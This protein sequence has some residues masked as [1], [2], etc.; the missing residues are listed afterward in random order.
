MKRFDDAMSYSQ[1]ALELFKQ[2]QNR[3]GE[4]ICYNQIGR[5]FK[6]KGEYEKALI[7]CFDAFYLMA[8]LR[9][10]LIREAQSES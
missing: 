3:Q 4:A 1:R 10:Q 6:F 9:I 2:V 5:I 8:K 7:N